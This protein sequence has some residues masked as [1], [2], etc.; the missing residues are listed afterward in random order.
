M[1]TLKIK[2]K[3]GPKPK[4]VTEQVV[5]QEEPVKILTEQDAMNFLL[6]AE[7]KKQMEIWNKINE[8]LDGKYVLSVQT[9]I[10]LKP[11]NN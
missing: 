6:D 10:V 2:Q 5:K 4:K 11:V 1:E 3:P 8:V 9:R 7:N